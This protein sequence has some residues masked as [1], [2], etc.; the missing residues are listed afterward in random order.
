M[1]SFPFQ[2]KVIF[3]FLVLVFS[4][5]IDAQIALQYDGVGAGA[6]TGGPLEFTYWDGSRELEMK[7]GM[8]VSTEDRR[9]RLFD[10][11]GGVID[12]YRTGLRD[13]L[14]F[15]LLPIG[16]DREERYTHLIRTVDVDGASG[17]VSFYGDRFRGARSENSTVETWYRSSGTIDRR[18]AIAGYRD[19]LENSYIL[20]RPGTIHY[21]SANGYLLWSRSLPAPIRRTFSD[22]TTVYVALSDGRLYAF[23]GE[24]E[25]SMVYRSDDP[26]QDI[27]VLRDENADFLVVLTAAGR[28]VR[29]N[30]SREGGDPRIGLIEGWSR[31]VSADLRTET[32]H[33]SQPQLTGQIVLFGE[34][35]EIVVYDANGHIRWEREIPGT[36]FLD[37]VSIPGFEGVVG[38]TRD[39]RIVAFDAMGESIG[40]VQLSDSPTKVTALPRLRQ[41][42]VEYPNWEYEVFSL[43]A[44]DGPPQDEGG[45][46][47]SY[48]DEIA[49]FPS[50]SIRRIG[51]GESA[52]ERYA[53]AV[54]SGVSQSDRHKLLDSIEDRLSSHELFGSVSETKTTLYRIAQE[55]YGGPRIVGGVVQNNFPEVRK[56]AVE[57][58]GYFGDRSTRR[59]FA[60]IVR[61]DP[62]PHVV[63][64]ALNS[65][66]NTGFDDAGVADWAYERFKTASPPE[67]S[68]LAEALVTFLAAIVPINEEQSE[69]LR[70]IALEIAAADLPGEIREEALARARRW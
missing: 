70:R 36:G 39:A 1:R 7:I 55:S 3:P 19:P 24:G 28:L 12:S 10:R 35:R 44:V 38:V 68:E 16:F 64:T 8:V 57:L 51:E 41:V 58:L 2:G 61:Y 4:V 65:A 32:I 37:V 23:Y 11:E 50:V 9:I 47:R 56:R 40:V 26:I 54:L 30:R 5:S 29:L 21:I 22:A 27:A 14:V 66:R 45:S 48:T 18:N 67:Q 43:D 17:V 20:S 42:V 53:D 25:G 13:P 46:G 33:F 49:V 52:L 62:E 34:G 15:D 59:M 69:R 60:S 63:S 31:D 6:I